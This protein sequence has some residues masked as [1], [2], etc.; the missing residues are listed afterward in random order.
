MN[1][2]NSMRGFIANKALAKKDKNFFLYVT[3][4]R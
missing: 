4:I 3:K 2:H 1:V